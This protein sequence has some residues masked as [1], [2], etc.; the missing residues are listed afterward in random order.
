LFHGQPILVD[1]RVWKFIGV[2]TQAMQDD[3]TIFFEIV[4]T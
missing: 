4:K 2:F 3:W 1:I